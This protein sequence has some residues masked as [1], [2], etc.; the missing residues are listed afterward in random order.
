[1]QENAHGLARYAVICQ[2]NGLVPIVEPE[3]LSDGNHDIK[4]CAA[5]TE[6]V[7]ATVY[8]A[9]SDH[10]VLLEGT[11]LKPNMVTPGADGL[12]V[13]PEQV[14]GYTLQCLQRCVPV[15]V[16]GV[17][18]LSGGQSEEEA[19]KNLNAINA[20]NAVKPWSLSFSFGR[21]LQHSA[22]RTWG[23]RRENVAEAQRVFTSLCRANSEA[24]LGNY[25]GSLDKSGGSSESLYVRDYKY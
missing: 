11:L 15:A 5:V 25:R 24:S 17:M 13:A 22:I 3:V 21:A 16:P 18:F 20:M 6:R 8:K 4:K 19:T 12:K 14:A 2:E 10:K 7:L 1:M 23:G 9:L